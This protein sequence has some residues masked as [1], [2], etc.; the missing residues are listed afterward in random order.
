MHAS[1]SLLLVPR[2]SCLSSIRPHFMCVHAKAETRN[3]Q[4]SNGR[5]RCKEYMKRHKIDERDRHG[6]HNKKA[7]KQAKKQTS[8]KTNKRWC[9]WGINVGL[10]RMSITLWCWSMDDTLASKTHAWTCKQACKGA[11]KANGWHKQAWQ[12][13]HRMKWKRERYAWS[14]RHYGDA[15]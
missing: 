11:Y 1:A 12:A 15:S 6:K 7:S 2:K 5:K 8:K 9:P 10:D 4:T 3:H 14:N 13:Y